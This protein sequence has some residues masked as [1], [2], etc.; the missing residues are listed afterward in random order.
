MCVCVSP[1]GC[2]CIHC[3]QDT[4][5]GWCGECTILAHVVASLRTPCWQN[6]CDKCFFNVARVVCVCVCV[7]VWVLHTCRKGGRER[8]RRGCGGETERRGRERVLS[9]LGVFDQPVLKPEHPQSLAHRLVYTSLMSLTFSRLL[10]CSIEF[11]KLTFIFCQC[12]TLL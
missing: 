9:L 11:V 2:T 7:C 10:E 3:G 1:I 8:E 12:G 5:S 6:R 4:T